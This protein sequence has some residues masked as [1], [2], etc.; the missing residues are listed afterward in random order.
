MDE[1]QGRCAPRY[2]MGIVDLIFGCIV[3]SSVYT[4]IMLACLLL[5]GVT[6]NS[7]W[8]DLF[9]QCLKQIMRYCMW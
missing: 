2:G 6:Q 8:L 3:M 4:P 5:F 7:K 9:V 1:K